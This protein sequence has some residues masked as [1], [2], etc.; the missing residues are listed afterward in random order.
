MVKKIKTDVDRLLLVTKL[1]KSS[2]LAKYINNYFY[3]Q[4]QKKSTY[5]RFVCHFANFKKKILCTLDTN[6]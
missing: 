4:S 1:K 2:I 5:V 6:M 3:S